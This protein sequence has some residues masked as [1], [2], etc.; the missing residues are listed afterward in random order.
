MLESFPLS[1]FQ[2]N[3]LMS[4]LACKGVQRVFCFCVDVCLILSWVSVSISRLCGHCSFAPLASRSHSGPPLGNFD[5][6]DELD[7]LP[8]TRPDKLSR[9]HLP[10]LL[11]HIPLKGLGGFSGTWHLEASDIQSSHHDCVIITSGA[12]QWVNLEKVYLYLHFRQRKIC[13]YICNI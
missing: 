10:Q 12:F 1:I 7:Q 13:K 6:S 2:K 8:L 11:P 3:E 9:A 4:Y 5:T